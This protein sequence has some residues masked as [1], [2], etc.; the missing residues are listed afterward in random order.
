MSQVADGPRAPLDTEHADKKWVLTRGAAFVTLGR[1][2]KNGPI[3]SIASAA[4]QL[5]T[6]SLRT[7]EILVASGQRWSQT[8]PTSTATARA[9]KNGTIVLRSTLPAHPGWS[10]RRVARTKLPARSA[11]KAAS[12]RIRGRLIDEVEAH[13]EK[14][15]DGDPQDEEDDRA[16]VVE[17]IKAHQPRCS[18]L[19]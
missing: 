11:W 8:P 10:I 18:G 13:P 12:P 19:L 15:G 1:G 2:R 5:K 16:F 7:S 6:H 14:D 4:H 9:M 3:P 17:I